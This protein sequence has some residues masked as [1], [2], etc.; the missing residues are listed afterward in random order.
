MQELKLL[1][2]TLKNFKGI[3][4]FTLQANGENAGVFGD[5]AT[6]KTTLFDA[7]IWLL[8]DKDSQNKKDFQI[9]TVTEEGQELH[10]LDHMVEATFSLN[11]NE[12]KL[13]K[14][15]K[16]KWTKKRGAPTKEFTGHTT[17][18]YIDDVPSK[19]KE[20]T[21]KVAEVVD[22][23]VF[24]L[25]TSPSYFNE[26]L[27]WQKRRD[28]LLEITGDVSQE[29]VIQSNPD[30]KKL[31]DYL[32]GR[33]I[34]DHKKVIKSKKSEINKELDRIP[35][36]VDEVNQSKP[37]VSNLNQQSLQSEID[38][39][40]S[41]IDEQ[42]QEKSRIQNGGQVSEKQKQLAEIETKL[43]QLK[44]DQQNLN[45]NKT[46]GKRQEL[47][48]LVS[49]ADQLQ[50]DKERKER[51][52]K[53]NQ[54]IIKYREKEMADLR[55]QWNEVNAEEFTS[56]HEENCP[57]CGQSLPEEQIKEA[58]EKALADFNRK[59]SD[60]LESITSKV[61]SAQ[62]KATQAQN[63]NAELKKEIENLQEEIENKQTEKEQLRK[64]IEQL[65]SDVTEATD[66]P[67]YQEKIKEKESILAE[68]NELK[69]NYQESLNKV[70]QKISE[71]QQ[72][73]RQLEQDQA[74][75]TQVQQANERISELEAKQQSL[76]E[77]YEQLEEQLYLTE[78]FTRSKVNLLERKINSEFHLAKFKLF[79][80]NINGGLEET[81]ETTYEGV[82]Y[83][84]LNNAARINVG[85]DII[86]TLSDYYG[87]RVPIFV[88]NREAV[89][90]LIDIQTQVI[91]LV[92]S[93][94][95]K[96]LRVN[97]TDKQKEAI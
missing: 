19:K 39:L 21:D 75:F 55:T 3:Q 15:Y 4:T 7:F 56:H 12:L 30:L 24:K 66:L 42:E 69:S 72:E 44:Q 89:T 50:H 58:H 54:D 37:D 28:L 25:L 77:E 5:N 20:F 8:F 95:D 70:T 6:G 67:E 78:E 79:T 85:L 10:N 59:R 82:P 91:S 45:H 22:E 52:V 47:N 90:K 38:H 84:S 73:K 26:Q 62:E 27:H 32:N 49:S 61:K 86:A 9:K 43:L 68:I 81:C 18:Y 76:A 87:I 74:K 1:N 94:S 36:R 16:E 2:L 65:E 51:K 48:A 33:S 63:E 92:V 80:E 13:A 34:E 23:G 46:N 41:L 60:R 97:Q 64:E 14:V 35:V 71:L 40:Q 57:T 93:E 88:D 11:G 31:L 53:D 29:E 17:D 96:Q 83:S